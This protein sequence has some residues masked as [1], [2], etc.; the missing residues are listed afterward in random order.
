MDQKT[1]NSGGIL[2]GVIVIICG[3]LVSPVAI[4]MLASYPHEIWWLGLVLVGSCS[5]MIYGGIQSI[6]KSKKQEWQ[7]NE[8]Q[9]RIQE[10][11]ARLKKSQ[12]AIKNEGLPGATIQG[13]KGSEESHPPYNEV[14]AFWTFSK[15]EW[16]KFLVL[17]KKRRKS[18]TLIEGILI[19]ALGTPFLMW[20]RASTFGTAFIIC[21]IIALIISLLRYFLT[22][23]SLGSVLDVNEVTI[24]DQTVMI[25]GKLNP[26]RS[27]NFWLDKV[28]ILDGDPAVLEFTY[29][30]NT[31][32]Q[33]KTFDE[34]RVPIP[35]K[36][37]AEAQA[38]IEKISKPLL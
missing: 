28:H 6:R 11:V 24:T 19:V 32:K 35:Q 10:E 18:S 21:L 5:L 3:V 34:L 27:D 7:A 36:K 14:L 13:Q 12:L 9:E 16:N 20:V 30:W 15:P 2:S 22:M 1:I 38:L 8:E 23:N 26:Y 25:N 37:R 4:G 33:K 31:R 17:E 29:A